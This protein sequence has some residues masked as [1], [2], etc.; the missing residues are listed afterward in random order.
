MSKSLNA[1]IF[2]FPIGVTLIA[3]FWLLVFSWL[4]TGTLF[5]GT[6]IPSLDWLALNGMVEEDVNGMPIG[7]QLLGILGIF[8]QT[9][10]LVT[11]LQWRDAS[12]LGEAV[13]TG[14]LAAITFSTP[15]VMLPL[16]FRP[17]HNVTL[18]LINLGTYVIGLP[19]TAMLILWLKNVGRSRGITS[20]ID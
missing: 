8:L 11:L 20:L 15:V 9:A 19:T 4:W 16:V 7:W 1:R 18:F 6:T 13:Q 2:G 14:L 12:K 10:G 17:E 5:N 3:S